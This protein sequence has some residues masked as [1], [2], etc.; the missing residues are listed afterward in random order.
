VQ[1]NHYHTDEGVE[2]G[3]AEQ[4]QR[5]VE[6]IDSGKVRLIPCEEVRRRMAALLYDAAK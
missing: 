2:A 5:R 4:I 1:L 6:E 3:W